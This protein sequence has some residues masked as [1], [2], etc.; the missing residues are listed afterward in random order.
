M[1][2]PKQSPRNAA[3]R[4]DNHRQESTAVRGSR[5]AGTIFFHLLL[6]R[7][8]NDH[9]TYNELPLTLVNIVTAGNVLVSA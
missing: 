7:V 6:S 4:G 3:G 5:R 2:H 9:V 1:Q 8:A